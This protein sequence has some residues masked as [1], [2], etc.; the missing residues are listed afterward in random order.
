MPQLKECERFPRGWHVGSKSFEVFV[1]DA[2]RSLSKEVNVEDTID[3]ITKWIYTY[4][5]LPKLSSKPLFKRALY[6]FPKKTRHETPLIGNYLG[7]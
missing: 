2:F 7:I 4:N 6:H 1:N 5:K 3:N